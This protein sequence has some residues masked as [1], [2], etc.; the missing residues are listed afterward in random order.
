MAVFECD[1]ECLWADDGANGRASDGGVWQRSDLKSLLSS[2]V[3]PLNLTDPRPLPGRIIPVPYVLTRDDAF[4][5]TDDLLKPYP[6]SKITVEKRIF[7]YRLSR[8]RRIPEDGFGILVSSWR[9]FC[10]P[11]LLEPGT[12]KHIVL[13]ALTL[14]NLLW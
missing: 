7:N 9:I 6:Q 3:N 11:M 13:A 2:E 5:L 10:T 4:A 1:Y 8:I 14:H 12:V